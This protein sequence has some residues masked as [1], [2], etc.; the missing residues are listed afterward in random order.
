MRGDLR[1]NTNID[2]FKSYNNDNILNYDT[3][4]V[5]IKEYNK[6]RISRPQSSIAKI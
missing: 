3:S 2:I 1:L 4:E 5:S 6:R